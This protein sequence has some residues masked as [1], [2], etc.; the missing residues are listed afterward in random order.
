[1]PITRRPVSQ[2]KPFFSLIVLFS[3]CFIH[4]ADVYAQGDVEKRK[5]FLEKM[6]P[7]LCLKKDSIGHTDPR[8]SIEYESWPE[9]VKKTGELPPDFDSLPAS[10][11]L[12]DPL[13]IRENGREV[14]VTTAKQWNKQREYFKKQLQHWIYGTMPPAAR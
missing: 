12:P 2:F 8:I 5:Q 7:F 9:W 3:F 6:T 14:P 4:W 13:V 11:E 1:M 10:A